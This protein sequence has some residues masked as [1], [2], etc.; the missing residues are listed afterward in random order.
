M[1]QLKQEINT[2]SILFCDYYCRVHEM[3]QIKS[4]LPKKDGPRCQAN[5]NHAG[6]RAHQR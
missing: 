2:E 1:N 3:A 6:F 5:V 4:H